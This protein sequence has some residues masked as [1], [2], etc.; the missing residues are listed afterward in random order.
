MEMNFSDMYYREE[1]CVLM[2]IF[3]NNHKLL[4]FIE[5]NAQPGYFGNIWYY[6]T[7]LII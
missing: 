7:K 2:I 5:I 6:F 1:V 4:R 3:H